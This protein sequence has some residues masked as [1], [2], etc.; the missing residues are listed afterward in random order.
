MKNMKDMK[1]KGTYYLRDDF[2]LL[3][4]HAL[5]VLHGEEF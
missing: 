3:T 5:H 2:E 1:K 4:L